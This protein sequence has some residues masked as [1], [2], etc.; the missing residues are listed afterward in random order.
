[1]ITVIFNDLS[2]IHFLTEVQ[3][4]NF[5]IA[6]GFKL[7]KRRQIFAAQTVATR[8]EPVIAASQTDH[9]FYRIRVADIDL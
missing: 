8:G 5:C 2:C 7:E 6:N 4:L 1:M 9:P 3:S